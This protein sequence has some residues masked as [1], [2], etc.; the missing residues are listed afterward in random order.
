MKEIKGIP[1]NLQQLLQNAKY[2]IDNYQR[3]Y[4]WQRRQVE[5]L[6]NDLTTEFFR[7]YEPIHKRDDVANY[8][9]YFMG[10]I[11]LAGRENAIV[12]GQQRLSSLTLLLMCLRNRL[13]KCNKSHRTVEGYDNYHAKNKFG[14]TFYRFMD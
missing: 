9:I 7:N 3:E 12:D 10:S 11:I 8:N 5:E 14:G 4:R 6:L 13:I 2:S 1:R